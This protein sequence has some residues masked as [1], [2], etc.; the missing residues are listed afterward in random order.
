[1]KTSPTG[2]LTSRLLFLCLFVFFVAIAPSSAA[3][4][5]YWQDVRPA[6]RKHCIACHNAR[7]VKEVEVSG[8]LALDS[9]DAILKAP[10]K[11]VVRPGKSGDSVLVHRVTSKDE[12]ERMPPGES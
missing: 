8:G 11:P 9:Y 7:N 4:P 10:R 5:T 3:G 12:A 1:M 6:L 2:G